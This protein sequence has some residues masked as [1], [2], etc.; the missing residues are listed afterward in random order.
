MKKAILLIFAL[1]LITG[2]SYAKEYEVTK[3]AGPYQVMASIDKN[4]PISGKNNMS[5]RISDAQGRAVTDVKVSID[6]VMAGMPDMPAASYKTNAALKGNIYKAEINF[7][8]SGPWTVTVKI[9]RAGKTE[10]MK[11]SIDVQ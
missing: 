5:V 6:Y 7:S 11:F 8:M 4:P 9:D 1:L 2:L 3:K 10:R